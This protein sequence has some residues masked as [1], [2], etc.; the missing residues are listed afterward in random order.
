MEK[1]MRYK[2]RYF[3]LFVTYKDYEFQTDILDRDFE[4]VWKLTNQN[5]SLILMIG[6]TLWRRVLI[7]Y[8]KKGGKNGKRN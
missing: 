8:N 4:N 5:N 2:R 7:I 6:M 1:I 3:W